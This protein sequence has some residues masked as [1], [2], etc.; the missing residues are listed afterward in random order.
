MMPAHTGHHCY[1]MMVVLRVIDIFLL[2]VQDSVFPAVQRS[3]KM[4]CKDGQWSVGQL[5]EAVKCEEVRT[6][7]RTLCW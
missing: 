7:Q 6:E 1:M 3:V 2:S 5:E 4:K